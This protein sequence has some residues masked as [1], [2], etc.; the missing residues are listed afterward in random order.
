MMGEGLRQTIER[1]NARLA[2]LIE[3]ARRALRGEGEFKAEDVRQ[4][5]EPVEE[6]A[7]IVAQSPDLR[8]AQPEIVGELDLYKVHLGE[9]QTTLNQ[10]RVMLLARQASL[11]SDQTHVSAVSRWASTLRQTR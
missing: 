2:G 9:L 4:L 11:C 8:L 6:M 7:P 5:R 10:L 1:V 3:N